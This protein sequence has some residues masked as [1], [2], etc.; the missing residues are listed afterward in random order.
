MSA[1]FRNLPAFA[2]KIF[3]V[4]LTILGHY[5]LKGYCPIRPISVTLINPRAQ[6]GLTPDLLK[7]ESNLIFLAVKS[8][9]LG[10]FRAAIFFH[11][12]FVVAV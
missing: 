6:K 1:R 3:K 9:K 10:G 8:N 11:A 7:Q 12:R 2:A 4:C 5:V